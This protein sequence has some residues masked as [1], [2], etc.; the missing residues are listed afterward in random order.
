[1]CISA[2]YIKQVREQEFFLQ[3]AI[4]RTLFEVLI[5]L[6]NKLMKSGHL[7]EQH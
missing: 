5:F 3:L 1:M 6:A 7:K 2:Q 4:Q